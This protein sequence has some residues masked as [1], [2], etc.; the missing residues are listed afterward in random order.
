MLT[1][2][3]LGASGFIGHRTV[4]ILHRQ[5]HQ[6]RPIGRSP[7]GFKDFADSGL[8]CR[9]ANALDQRALQRA[10]AGCDILVHSILGSPGLIRASAVPA[11]RAAQAVGVRRLI[12]LSSM[13]V[14]SQA[15]APGTTEES[16]L[17]DRQLFPYNTAKIY[18]ERQLLKLRSRGRVEVVIFR[19][20][21]VFGPRSR[22]ITNL[23]DDLLKGSA[24]LINQGSGVCNTVY[25]DN[26]VQAMTLAM[27]VPEADGQAFFVGELELVTWAKFF[28][29]IATALGIPF[30]QIHSARVPGFERSWQ[31]Q[32]KA[33]LWD[34]VL[35][36]TLL[37]QVSEEMKQGI[38]QGMFWK[39]SRT[40]PP[41][42]P[43]VSKAKVSVTAEMAALQ[44]CEFKLPLDKAQQILGYQ[45]RV[46]FPQ[47]MD[48]CIEWLAREGYPIVLNR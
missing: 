33:K 29:S 25:V 15:P 38:K 43:A 17:S 47:A 9:I 28:G 48:D 18:A 30:E 3:V 32:L 36:Q 12:F 21:I 46:S 10:V 37:A 34:S 26:L 2:G 20:G 22:W 1:I 39:S 45:P 44:Q 23:A 41:L 14:H 42:D 13:C 35:A 19:P 40:S 5:G 7:G 11:Y 27:T 8:D 16:V 24:Y 6:V 4:E 31:Q